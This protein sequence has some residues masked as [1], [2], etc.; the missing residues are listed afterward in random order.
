MKDS[1]VKSKDFECIADTNKNKNQLTRI[2]LGVKPT[3]KQQQKTLKVE[4]LKI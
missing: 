2:I 4:T 1:S 3:Q